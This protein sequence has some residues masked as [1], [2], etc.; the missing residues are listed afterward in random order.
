[1]CEV[2]TSLIQMPKWCEDQRNLKIGDIVILIDEKNPRGTCP[3]GKVIE[4]FAAEDGVVR[5][6]VVQTRG[7]ELKRPSHNLCLLEPADG[8]DEGPSRNGDKDV[9]GLAKHRACS[10]EKR[11][12]FS[13]AAKLPK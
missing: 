3:L 7:T 13:P 5:S 9:L 12:T 2:V 4:T 1:M 8:P 6:V 10:V 11:V